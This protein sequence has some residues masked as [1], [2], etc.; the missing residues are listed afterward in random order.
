MSESGGAGPDDR[1]GGGQVRRDGGH[2]LVGAREMRRLE[3][4]RAGAVDDAVQP[5]V[6]LGR[7]ADASIDRVEVRG[8]DG[9]PGGAELL[10][11]GAGT[12]GGPSGEG[13][14]RAGRGEAAGEGAADSTGGGEDHVGGH[15]AR[16]DCPGVRFP[17]GPA[18]GGESA[19][20]RRR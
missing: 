13:E 17:L 1:E 11:Q 6:A 8:I 4:Q 12:L 15:A 20:G 19:R 16:S 18:R 3:E 2:Q 14:R 10:A 9:R 7:L 5:A